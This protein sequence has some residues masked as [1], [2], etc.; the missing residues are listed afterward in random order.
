VDFAHALVELAAEHLR[1][2]EVDGGKAAEEH[3]CGHRQVEMTDDV[4]RVV[5]V[6][7]G[8]DRAEQ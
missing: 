1:K 2:P 5:Q 6:K 4:H 3:R 7:I 8:R